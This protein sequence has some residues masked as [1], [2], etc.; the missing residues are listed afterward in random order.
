[1]EVTGV[2]TE[3][4]GKIS[5]MDEIQQQPGAL[6]RFIENAFEEDYLQESLAKILKKSET[7]QIILTGMGSSLFGCYIMMNFLRSRGFQACAVESYELQMAGNRFITKDT[8]IIAVSQSGE[9]PE[10]LELFKTL[11]ANVPVV[12]VTNY[13]NSHLRGMTELAGGI[14]AGTEFLTS[15]KSYTNTLAA[16]LLLGHRIAGC[17]PDEFMGLR[18]RMEECADQMERL[19]YEKETGH[20]IEKFIADIDFLI[21]V[22]SGYSYTTACHSEIVAEEA[23][24]FYSSCFTPAQFIHGPIELICPGFGTV[25]Y[26]FDRNYSQKCDMVR[27]SVLKYGG[28]VLMITNRKDVKQQENQMIYVIDHEDPATATLLEIIPLELG[29]D[30]LCKFRGVAAGHLSRVVKRI[31]N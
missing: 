4:R 3:I 10:V 11:P 27:E 13:P 25:I 14:Y 24:K 12:V 17:G 23:G 5:F 19:I 9:S 6:R 15:T 8:I 28:K 26:D 20:R 1:M 18:K 16:M 31:A 29:I 7:P 2:E 22:G 21:F 30:S